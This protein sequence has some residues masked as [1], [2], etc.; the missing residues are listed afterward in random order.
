MFGLFFTDQDPITNFSQVMVCHQERFKKFFHGMLI[1]GI[2]LAPS[3]FEAGF[4][5][6]AHG[7]REITATVEAAG[8]VMHSL[9]RL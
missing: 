5:S 9:A 6:S 1:A 7:D 2:Y 4:V 8:R 3:A